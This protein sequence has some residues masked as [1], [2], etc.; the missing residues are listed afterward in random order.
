MERQTF[1]QTTTELIRFQ[2]TKENTKQKKEAIDYIKQFFSSFTIVET[3]KDDETAL[4]ITRKKTR[5]PKIVLCAHL[6]VVEGKENQFTPNV[7][8]KRIYGR[9]SLDD[10]GPLAIAMHLV[11]EMEVDT[12]GLIVTTDEEVGGHNG[13]KEMLKK[14][15]PKNAIIL[16][17]G[18]LGTYVT[19]AK[20]IIFTR[21]SATGKAA[22]SSRPWQGRNA[23]NLLLSGYHE[24]QKRYPVKNETWNTT[25]NAGYIKSGTAFNK[26]PDY[27]E[28]GIDI[29]YSDPQEPKRLK[30]TLT[31]I[32]KR[33]KG[34]SFE[35][36]LNE[37]I[38]QTDESSALMQKLRQSTATVLGTQAKITHEYGGSDA[39]FFSAQ[40]IPCVVTNPKGD[41]P[42]SQKEYIEIE[43]AEKLAAILTHTLLTY[44]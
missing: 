31:D 15:K 9:G 38:F 13:M 8:Q 41:N 24:L 20:G 3:T 35:I 2:T 32:K 7:T 11:K 12:I 1:I 17:G 16:D 33:H 39:R 5:H 40:K 19:Q 27:A 34:F 29:R 28:M 37:P 30:R 43:S 22:H 18:T 44:R 25:L 21:L 26:V 6:D 42:H 10:K 23:L 4:F 36:I 14:I